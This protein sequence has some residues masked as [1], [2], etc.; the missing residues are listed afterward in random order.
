MI[1]CGLCIFFD[2][3]GGVTDVYLYKTQEERVQQRDKGFHDLNILG[4]GGILT[5]QVMLCSL[6]FPGIA[7][8]AATCLTCS[9]TEQ[10]CSPAS[11]AGRGSRGPTAASSTSR[12][13]AGVS[14]GPL[15]LRLVLCCLDKL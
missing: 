8:S 5:A 6:L 1:Y 3:F 9:G 11:I 2:D 7:V 14:A 15:T 12:P 10:A 4:M 13:A